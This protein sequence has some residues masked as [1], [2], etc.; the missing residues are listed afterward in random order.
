M[1]TADK[2]LLAALVATAWVATPAYA[3]DTAASTAASPPAKP[4]AAH[5]HGH[6]K[7]G[8]PHAAHGQAK[9]GDAKHGAAH[10]AHAAHGQAKPVAAGDAPWV[11]AEVQKVDV[12][13]GKV[14][15]KHAP[16]PNLKMGA[17][18]MGFRAQDPK[19]LATLK[20]GDKVRAKFD[21]V[22]GMFT[23]TAI[24]PSPAK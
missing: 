11:D 3:A 5:P 18:T 12:A 6:A 16:I 2:R 19:W 9:P 17:M 8:D 1:K 4:A 13:Q 7:A 20:P 10:A 21:R 24:E 14:S 22:N 23:V 15:L